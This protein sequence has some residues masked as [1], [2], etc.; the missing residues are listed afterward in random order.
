MNA[1]EEN[2]DKYEPSTI[3][4]FQRSIQDSDAYMRRDIWKIQKATSCE[5]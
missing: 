4:S 5:T 3:S 2:G 1:R